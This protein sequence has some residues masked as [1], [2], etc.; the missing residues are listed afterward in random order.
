METSSSHDLNN[1]QLE[2]G[3]ILDHLNT[4]LVCYSD[5]HCIGY[6]NLALVRIIDWQY[7]CQILHIEYYTFYNLERSVLSMVH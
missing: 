6:F 7:C 5:P 3:T 1:E 2:E 4:E